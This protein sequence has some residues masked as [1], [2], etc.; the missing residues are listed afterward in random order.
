MVP[1]LRR[2]SVSPLQWSYL[3]DIAEDVLVIMSTPTSRLAD[4]IE[5]AHS[6]AW[7]GPRSNFITGGGLSMYS[8]D[9]GNMLSTSLC[10]QVRYGENFAPLSSS[11]FG[12]SDHFMD[13]S[14]KKMI[15]VAKNTH[16]SNISFSVSGTLGANGFGLKQT[17]EFI[18]AG[19]T[20]YITSVCDANVASVNHLFIVNSVSPNMTHTFDASTAS[21]GD[22]INGIAPG[23]QLLYMLYSSADGRCM[24]AASHRQLFEAAVPVLLKFTL[25]LQPPSSPTFRIQGVCQNCELAE[26][27]Y[28]VIPTSTLGR[29]SCR[30]LKDNANLTG[31]V[32]AHQEE[33]NCDYAGGDFSTFLG[34]N[35]DVASQNV[36]RSGGQ[37]TDPY[38]DQLFIAEFDSDGTFTGDTLDT[39]GTRL[40]LD[41]EYVDVYLRGDVTLAGA[42]AGRI[43]SVEITVHVSVRDW[44]N[45]VMWRIGHGRTFGPY[46]WH[47]EVYETMTVESGRHTMYTIDTASD[48]WHGG[49]WE[50]RI[51]DTVI[52]GPEE[53]TGTGGSIE[54][55][56]RVPE[57]CRAI[58]CAE[59]KPLFETH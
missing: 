50:I 9:R 34:Y 6:I 12:G 24:S 15:L 59:L 54:F 58:R 2:K 49:L 27:I 11:C 40:S 21:D 56:V 13:K 37:A 53:V 42:L 46:S 31:Y 38:I 26:S 33:R 18:E 22:S 14:P 47:T 48:G 20:G 25:T 51:G 5:D 39:Q 1:T 29:F 45:E 36:I 16:A 3:L 52:A 35:N 17:F 7:N 28:A 19:F 23:V 4:L 32:L 55:V 41:F 8:G 57:P 44:G 43:T 30:D 10:T